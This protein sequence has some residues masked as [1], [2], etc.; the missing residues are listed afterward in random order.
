MKIEL[1][2]KDLK[3]EVGHFLILNI[4]DY[5][6]PNIVRNQEEFISLNG[7]KHMGQSIQEWTK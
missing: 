1:K 4:G 5:S 6:P 2:D 7:I 3:R